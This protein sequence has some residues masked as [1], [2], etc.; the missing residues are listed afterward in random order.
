MVAPSSYGFDITPQSPESGLPYIGINGYFD[1]GF[2][3]NG[4]QPRN[5]QNYDYQDNFTKIV[6]AHNM[7]FGAHIERFVVSNPFYGNNNGNFGYGGSG[8]F[9]SGDPL[10]DFFLGIPDT[11]AQGSGGWINAAAW[12]YYFYAQDNW[13]ISPSLTFNYG[14]A[15]DTETPNRMVQ[16]NKLG[17]T[18]FNVGGT[19]TSQ[20]FKNGPPGMTWPGDPGCN[21]SGGPTTKWGHVGPRIGFAFSPATGPRF[22]IGEEGQHAFA[23]RA[24]FG[25]YWNRDQ[26]EGQLQNLSAPP[27]G[28]TASGAA[29]VSGFSAG[30]ASPYTDVAGRGSASNPF[31]FTNPGPGAT[32]N[33]GNYPPLEL[34]EFDSHYTSPMVYNFNL[35]VQRQLPGSMVATFG[36]VGSLGRHLILVYDGDPITP[37]GHA[38]CEANPAC[39][40][41]RYGVHLFFPQ[42]AI[43]PNY[44]NPNTGSPWF[45]GV[46]VQASYG[47]SN[48]NAL[49]ISLQKQTTHGLMFNLAY[50]YSHGL[51][52]ASG[53]E[54]SGFNG[55]G[56][57][58]VPGY[59]YLSYGDSDYDARHRFVA[60]YVYQIPIGNLRNNAIAREALGGWRISGISALQTGFPV[61]LMQTSGWNSLWCDAYYYYYCA[62][63]PQTTTFHLKTMNPRNPTNEW[64]N[65]NNFSSEPIG[66][67]G[68]TKRNYFH[69]PGY[70][71]TNFELAKDFPIHEQMSLELQLEA[72]DLFNHA[73]FAL[74]DGN[75][76]DGPGSFAV[77]TWVIQP[78]GG[79]GDPQPGRAVQL[80]AKFYF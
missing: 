71:Y 20:V 75:F 48:Y 53:L 77:I 74:P 41:N 64:F 18:C 36:Y 56:Y 70:D 9:S 49:Q 73:N 57:N 24:G 17:V 79:T 62:D 80:A 29:A 66:T 44:T 38:D 43:Q 32:I 68:N 16:Y 65:P 42:Y 67:F 61:T 58:W 59:Q 7:K 28:L 10:L 23:V 69:G 22:L 54:S 78:P 21:D 27:F 12:E 35:N 40:A 15:W 34:N 14:L 46:G 6:G 39:V 4:P 5:D 31:P 33:W 47:T 19:N 25:L 50:T 30:F 13:K 2:S 63:S 3:T 72:F 11:Y 37:S 45:G 51:D 52:N 8:S 1:L 26:E 55:R 76:S 60:L